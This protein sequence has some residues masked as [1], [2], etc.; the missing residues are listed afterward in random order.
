MEGSPDGGSKDYSFHNKGKKNF[1]GTGFLKKKSL[2][3]TII[4]YLAIRECYVG[5]RG[6]FV[7]LRLLSVHTQSEDQTH[8]EKEAYFHELE[9]SYNSPK[10]G[11][12]IFLGDFNVKIGM[13]EVLHQTI[14][15]FITYKSSDN[16]VKVIDFAAQKMMRVL[17]TFN[18]IRS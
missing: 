15:Q 9:R 4:D 8:E 12:K 16:R 2:R 3:D 5:L 1:F 11:M 13:D 17:S 18:S 10:H 14:D 7:N 6:K